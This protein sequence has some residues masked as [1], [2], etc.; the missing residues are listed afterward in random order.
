MFFRCAWNQLKTIAL[1]ATSWHV[2][3]RLKKKKKRPASFLFFCHEIAEKPDRTRCTLSN[4]AVYIHSRERA[5]PLLTSTAGSNELVRLLSYLKRILS[6]KFRK[7][8]S[9][10]FGMLFQCARFSIDTWEY[11][12]PRRRARHECNRGVKGYSATGV[13]YVSFWYNLLWQ[14]IFSF[15]VTPI[16]A[17]YSSN[18]AIRLSWT[19]FESTLS[20]TVYMY[21]SFDLSKALT[22]VLK[23]YCVTSIK[24]GSS[25]CMILCSVERPRILLSIL[26]NIVII[27]IN[28][29]TQYFYVYIYLNMYLMI[30][31]HVNNLTN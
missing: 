4:I 17:C 3:I 16:G 28:I 5:Y 6:L 12:W 27:V 14:R 31:Y 2:V 26:I 9:F 25:Y 19:I 13:P 11:C 15:V 18:Y 10:G 8:D 29:N 30:K 20:S 21:T 7:A 22:R 23:I 24:V 1:S